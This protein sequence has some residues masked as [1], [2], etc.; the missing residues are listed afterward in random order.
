M[1]ADRL[2]LTKIQEVFDELAHGVFFTTLDFCSGYWRI[3]ISDHCKE[4]TA[5]VCRHE[6]LQFEVKPSGLMNAP[7][8]FQRM[9]D[10]LLAH[11]SFVNVYVY[12]VAIISKTLSEHVEHIRQV[13]I[14]VTEHGLKIKIK[15]CEFAKSQEDLLGHT[16]DK[17]GIRVDPNKVEVILFT[18]RPKCQRYFQSVHGIA[19][20]YRKLIRSLTVICAPLHA[21]TYSIVRF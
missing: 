18:P 3:K 19:G 5:F 15:K 14:L 7:W 12:D 6:L 17:T 20:C 9:T 11:L 13:I 10:D 2:P 4:K 8:T 16:V 1:K 21:M